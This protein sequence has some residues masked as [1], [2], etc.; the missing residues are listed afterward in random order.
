MAGRPPKP[1]ALR[2][3][4][5]N[6]R[7]I[8]TADYEASISGSVFAPRGRP[9]TPATL[10]TPIIGKGAKA[11]Q[12]ELR[13]VTALSHWEY[14]CDALASTG[15]LAI[16]DGGILESMCWCHALMVESATGGRVKEYSDLLGRYT[17]A[18]NAVGLTESART[19]LSVPA[20]KQEDAIEA[21]LNDPVRPAAQDIN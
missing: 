17:T 18:S 5:G 13:R 8:S 16:P 2:A 4:D 12:A 9:A 20:K 14:L 15:L 7:K 6:T 3:R 11:R 1:A 10:T 21:F 19:K